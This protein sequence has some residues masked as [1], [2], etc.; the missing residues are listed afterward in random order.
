MVLF[1]IDL[2]NWQ[3]NFNVAGAA[4]EG[5]AAAICKTS[6][7]TTYLDGRFGSFTQQAK[8]A[9]MVPGAYHFLRAGDGAAQARVFRNAVA[10]QGGPSG[11][12]CACDNEADA[13]W[14]T[15][16]A[17][18]TEWNRLTGG[19]PLAMY[20]GA[21]WWGARGWPGSQLTPYL[22]NSRYVGGSG[23]ASSLYAGVPD[24]WW[25]PGYGGWPETTILQ[26]SS[27][28][29]VAGQSIDVNAYR[30]TREQLLTLTQ[31]GGSAM[32][33]ARLMGADPYDP[34]GQDRQEAF[35][36]DTFYAVASGYEVPGKS[37]PEGVI[38][39]LRRLQATAEALETP[40]LNLTTEQLEVL[41]ADMRAA[42]T[43][44]I[45]QELRPLL[46]QLGA[47]GDALG[48]LNDDLPAQG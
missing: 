13:S 18:Y 15:T 47:A 42:V 23:Y 1:L 26:F 36:R 25:T 28:G 32:T 11:F 43:S 21:W 24:S 2:S 3:G 22:W 5:F 37:T 33:D 31:K 27:S 46:S 12:I 8:T 4:A 45:R 14:A 6:E 44:T 10:A 29:R 17:F 38:G 16:Q 48:V 30:G 34:T 40:P 9:G 7:G 41:R 35:L 20:S 39:R 19:H